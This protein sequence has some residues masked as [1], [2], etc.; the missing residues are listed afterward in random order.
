MK[1][2]WF[3]N[4]KN[5][6]SGLRKNQKVYGE[7]MLGFFFFFEEIPRGCKSIACQ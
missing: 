4:Q 1:T 5:P 7:K 2:P 3:Q 6:D